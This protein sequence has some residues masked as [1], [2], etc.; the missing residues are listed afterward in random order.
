[1]RP[2]SHCAAV[3]RPFHRYTTIALVS[4]LLA[5]VSFAA[6]STPPSELFSSAPA[7]PPP[8]PTNS[9]A[10]PPAPLHGWAEVGHVWD[11]V[12]WAAIHNVTI[13]ILWHVYGIVM[14][15]AFVFNLA[16]TLS[17]AGVILYA[18]S[19]MATDHSLNKL[20]GSRE[21]EHGIIKFPA[22]FLV[23]GVIF[24]FMGFSIGI[25]LFYGLLLG[26]LIGVGF[27]LAIWLYEA[28][29]AKESHGD[30]FTDLLWGIA[31]LFF[32]SCSQTIARKAD[33]IYEKGQRDAQEQQALLVEQGNGAGPGGGGY[34]GGGPGGGG[35]GGGGFAGA[36][37]VPQ[38]YGSTQVIVERPP[39][40]DPTWGGPNSRQQ[41][42]QGQQGRSGQKKGGG[43][44]FG[45]C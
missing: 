33:E 39:P 19:T 40:M 20:F 32:R 35:P 44:C 17:A 23:F 2:S 38:Q 41:L 30:S 24:L 14:P 36:G 10:A 7:S 34:Y 13:L 8:P 3:T 27:F 15:V 26:F 29:C 42:A 1:M 9:T 31:A 21:S 4:A 18:N 11:E 16:G 5:A 12:P 28:C 25:S 37:G 43:G 22:A 45:S 6:Y